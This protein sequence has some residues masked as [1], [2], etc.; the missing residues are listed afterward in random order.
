[1]GACADQNLPRLR[2]LLEP[3]GDVHGVTR[4]ERAALA[5]H[6]LAGVDAH[7]D[8]QLGAELALK[9]CIEA[10]ELFAQ[11]VRGPGCAKC[12]V[13]VDGG[14]PED[15]HDRIAD[16][17]LHRAPVA[18][19]HV[20]REREVTLHHAPERLRVEPLAQGGRAG[21][22]AEEDGHGL[23]DLARRRRLHEPC[24]TGTAEPEP[25]RVLGATVRTDRHP[26]SVTRRDRVVGS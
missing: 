7:P 12:I 21:D 11:L 22:V 8:L 1:V 20:A 13:L 10:A 6:H 5:R 26:A 2:G 14:D 24:A 25:R 16:E 15:S 17:L 3:R 19:E 18:L 23:P 4:R 9:V